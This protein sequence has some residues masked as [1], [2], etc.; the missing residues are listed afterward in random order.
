MCNAA[1]LEN[2]SIYSG[3]AY[4]SYSYQQNLYNRYAKVDGIAKTD[5]YSARAGY[6]EHQTG[7]AIDI[8]NANWGYIDKT[9]KEYTWLINNSYKYGFI[10][11]YPEDKEKITGYMYEPWHYRYVGIDLAT[12]LVK[13]NLT[14]EEYIAKK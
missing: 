3:S 11:R 6:S 12:E 10:L 13:E 4:R 7:L 1:K 2:I 14:Y 5:T 8:M 9:D